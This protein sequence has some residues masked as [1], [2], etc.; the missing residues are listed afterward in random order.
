M[1][2]TGLYVYATEGQCGELTKATDLWG[3]EINRQNDQADRQNK[4]GL[5]SAPVINTIAQS[6]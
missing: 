2:N 5:L 3:G 4:E 6:L 1:R